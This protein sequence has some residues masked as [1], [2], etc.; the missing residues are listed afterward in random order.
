MTPQNYPLT[1]TVAQVRSHTHTHTHS[2]KKNFKNVKDLAQ[3]KAAIFCY[4]GSV[5]MR[6]TWFNQDNSRVGLPIEHIHGY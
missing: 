1:S 4:T 6:I 5:E 3:I 2:N